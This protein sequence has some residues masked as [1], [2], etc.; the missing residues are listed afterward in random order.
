ML[1]LNQVRNAGFA[2]LMIS[3]SQGAFAS[4]VTITGTT[5]NSLSVT[6]SSGDVIVTMSLPVTN[7]DALWLRKL[8]TGFTAAYSAAL[9][10]KA[11]GATA[12]V[13]VDNASWWPGSS[14]G[15]FCQI[16]AFRVD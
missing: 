4:T 7:C 15:H 10:A 6:T 16:L 1:T 9:A 5:V 12:T 8:D 13:A 2:A 14:S 3:I 11:A